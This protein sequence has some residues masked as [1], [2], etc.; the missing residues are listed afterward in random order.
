MNEKPAGIRGL[1]CPGFASSPH[2][3]ED[4]HQ[5]DSRIAPYHFD[6]GVLAVHAVNHYHEP[7]N[8]V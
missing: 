5:L 1:G 6:D 3:K 8:T 2:T 7:L 4:N